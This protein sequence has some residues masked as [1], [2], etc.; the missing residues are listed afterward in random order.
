MPELAWLQLV[1]DYIS[2]LDNPKALSRPFTKVETPKVI[3]VPSNDEAYAAE[4]SAMWK[5]DN[6]SGFDP[7]CWNR[8][9]NCHR[10]TIGSFSG[11]SFHMDMC[12]DPTTSI[13]GYNTSPLR[14]RAHVAP[15]NPAVYAFAGGSTTLLQLRLADARLPPVG[16]EGGLPAPH[17]HMYHQRKTTQD[18]KE[19]GIATSNLLNG[20]I[21]WIPF[22]CELKPFFRD[23]QDGHPV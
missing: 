11:F 16:L 2:S 22:C 14:Q 1:G 9:W 20:W 6:D 5:D 4:L 23:P 18:L 10:A 8:W 15:K 12:L 21:C 19:I 3:E 17:A 13:R 7:F